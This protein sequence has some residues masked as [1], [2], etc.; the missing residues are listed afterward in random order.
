MKKII[1][2][3]LALCV[4]AS[5]L[6]AQTPQSSLEI[7]LLILQPVVQPNAPGESGFDEAAY[8]ASLVRHL[9]AALTGFSPVSVRIQRTREGM[10]KQMLSTTHGLT[11]Y[12]TPSLD[13]GGV[14]ESF[15]LWLEDMK[16]MV[17]GDTIVQECKYL[18]W[19][20]RRRS[21]QAYGVVRCAAR[22][23][24]DPD[25]AAVIFG[26]EL[27]FKILT[28]DV[29]PLYTVATQTED[30]R[31]AVR[32]KIMGHMNFHLPRKDE[33]NPGIP[34]EYE[35]PQTHPSVTQYFSNTVSYTPSVEMVFPQKG[36]NVTVGVELNIESL[37]GGGSKTLIVS[38]SEYPNKEKLNIR[39]VGIIFGYS[40]KLDDFSPSYWF[41][42]GRFDLRKYTG[43]SYFT[44]YKVDLKFKNEVSPGLSFGI[45]GVPD[46]WPIGLS[47]EAGLNFGSTRLTNVSSGGQSQDTDFKLSDN[48]IFLKLGTYFDWKLH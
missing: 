27:S 33:D 8:T 20:N 25:S 26:R 47:A 19:N 1:Y 32:F 36:S 37:Q 10:S 2:L 29:S 45:E 9:P 6:T 24:A 22:T 21:T 14:Q 18:L 5:T 23:G 30:R 39:S 28:P 31:I 4:P 40:Q 11:G 13:P 17:N 43:A 38:E 46:R 44:G 12:F 34:N 42:K 15:A 16:A 41:V 48:R 7:K 3:M 35:N